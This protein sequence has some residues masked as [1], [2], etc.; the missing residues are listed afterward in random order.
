MKIFSLI[1][2]LYGA[3][4]YA[5]VV[6][7]EKLYQSWG[8]DIT[9]ID[10]QKAKIMWDQERIVDRSCAGCH[11]NNLTKY[12]THTRTKKKIKPLSKRVNSKRLS[13]V[14]KINKWLKRNCKFTYKR[15]CNAQ[16]K[17]NFIEFIKQN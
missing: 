14:K 11:T 6:D 10:T 17:M 1:M 8:A 12:G 13:S 3:N 2:L 16:E 15:E 7:F 9:K 5:N 4:V